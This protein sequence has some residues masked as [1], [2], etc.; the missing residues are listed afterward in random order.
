MTRSARSAASRLREMRFLLRVYH[1][2]D[3]DTVDAR[4]VSDV[5]SKPTGHDGWHTASGDLYW[6]LR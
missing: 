6:D 2:K 5:A 4:K 3:F 1:G